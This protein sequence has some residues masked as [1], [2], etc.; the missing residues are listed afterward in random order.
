MITKRPA[1]V[2]IAAIVAVVFGI[3]TI[4]SGGSVLFIDGEARRAA[5]NTVDF[6]LWFNFSAGFVY[7]ATGIGIWLEK[8]WAP[9]A[10]ITIATLTLS[11]FVA[12]GIYIFFGGE[13]ELRTVAA[14]TLRSVI[15]IV[16]G[17]T[18]Y[19]AMYL[20][21]LQDRTQ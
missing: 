15:W 1:W 2:W 14:M 16:I 9:A 5:E 6:V 21:Q 20:H 18:G 19:R 8:A 13:Y 17:I 4:K 3:M 7:I 11:V 10:A 12:F